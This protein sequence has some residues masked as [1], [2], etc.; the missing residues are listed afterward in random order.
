MNIINAFVDLIKS[1]IRKALW[2]IVIALF[3]I[4]YVGF[5]VISHP[6]I[7]LWIIVGLLVLVNLLSR[8]R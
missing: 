8:K 5:Y 3:G 4:Y 2:I 6:Q 1:L 7:L